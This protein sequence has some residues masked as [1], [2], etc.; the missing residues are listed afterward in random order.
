MSL[1]MRALLSDTWVWGVK[2]M[3]VLMGIL[4]WGAAAP[5]W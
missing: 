2:G 1:A 4:L 3:G 5:C